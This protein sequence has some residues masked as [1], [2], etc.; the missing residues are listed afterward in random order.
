MRIGMRPMSTVMV[1]GVVMVSALLTGCGPKNT[2]G[3]GRPTTGAVP[4]TSSTS[5]APAPA[6]VKDL[7]PGNCTLYSK[8][9]AVKLLGA[10]NDNN[11]ALAIG[12]D[13][14]TKI[15]LCSYLDIV[16]QNVKG[17]TYAVV[18]YDSA[19]TAFAE[20]QKVQ[21]EMLG[22][23]AGNNWPVQ[24]LTT[25]VPNAGQVLGGYGT[26]TEQG[27]TTTIA[28][29]GTNVGPYLV[30]ALGASDQSA[31]SAQQYALTLFQALS[32]DGQLIAPG[33]RVH[34]A[35]YPHAATSTTPRR[36]RAG[37]NGGCRAGRPRSML[38]P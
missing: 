22:T 30:A 23:A 24:T 37:T 13:G 29:V 32:V 19:A 38:N 36:P 25:P 27:L 14:G 6:T 11:K 35:R 4:A 9:D 2:T 7:T 26:K 17:V 10:V 28:V 21:T 18:R 8:A 16:G 5:S 31:T 1:A 12:T 33:H 34:E 3:S 20:A 15:D